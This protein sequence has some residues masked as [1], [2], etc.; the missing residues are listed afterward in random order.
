MNRTLQLAD[1]DDESA[2]FYLEQLDELLQGVHDAWRQG[3]VRKTR[4]MNV[5][6]LIVLGNLRDLHW[7]KFSTAQQNQIHLLEEILP[8]Y[9]DMT[10]QLAAAYASSSSSSSSS[11]SK[12][13]DDLIDKIEREHASA[14]MYDKAIYSLVN[15]TYDACQSHRYKDV[16]CLL[17]V[18]SD[19]IDRF[20]ER[21]P[22]LS[23]TPY[24]RWYTNLAY[25]R[26]NQ[27]PYLVMRIPEIIN[28]CYPNGPDM[29]EFVEENVQ[30]GKLTQRHKYTGRIRRVPIGPSTQRTEPQPQQAQQNYQR[31]PSKTAERK[32]DPDLHTALANL[33]SSSHT[34]V[35][36]GGDLDDTFSQ[37][38]SRV[39]DT[40]VI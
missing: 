18:T 30:Q 7:T 28:A 36:H 3:D 6:L 29:W 15:A 34:Q 25:I 20:M 39:C 31:L 5:L 14:S 26:Y 13:D 19:V 11:S 12:H 1:E 9:E 17:V 10:L 21:L 24:D 16:G 4:C 22:R 38:A 35:T 8:D 23:P 40:V 32:V 27:I 33:K 37:A 2:A